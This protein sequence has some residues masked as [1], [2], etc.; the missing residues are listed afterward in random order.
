MELVGR[1]CRWDRDR[2]STSPHRR[3]TGRARS[4]SPGRSTAA[5]ISPPS[6]SVTPVRKR[7]RD[8]AARALAGSTY[9]AGGA[10]SCIV[11]GVAPRGIRHATHPPPKELT[12]A[13][14]VRGR[15]GVNVGTDGTKSRPTSH[16][17]CCFNVTSLSC[18]RSRAGP[19]Q[20]RRRIGARPAELDPNSDQRAS[21]R[22]ADVVRHP[23]HLRPLPRVALLGPL[24]R[25]VEAYLAADGWRGSVRG[26]AGRAGP[27]ETSTSRAGSTF[28][29][30]C[31]TT[32]S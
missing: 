15:T 2:S 22:R 6:P 29:P 14:C 4:R 9:A 17:D 5:P 8:T 18:R 11:P 7:P 3:T 24:P 27:C 13:F 20:T 30:S 32:C 12:P 19:G 21:T 1:S 16:S 10:C 26:R 31:Q 25:R 23:G 28:A